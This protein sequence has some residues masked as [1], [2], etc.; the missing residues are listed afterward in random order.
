[1]LKVW[2]ILEKGLNNLGNIYDHMNQLFKII[3]GGLLEILLC[4]GKSQF[5]YG[6]EAFEMEIPF[7]FLLIF[8]S[9]TDEF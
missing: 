6:I 5:H 2:N 8:P 1:M 4:F 3:E 7:P 9:Y